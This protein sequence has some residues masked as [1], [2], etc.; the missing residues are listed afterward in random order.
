MDPLTL[1]ASRAPV[2]PPSA[3]F[4]NP[5]LAGL[6]PLTVTDEGRV[7]GHVAGWD[8]CHEGVIG[9]CVRPPRSKSGYAKFH[10]GVM[11]TSDGREVPVGKLTIM[12]GH[13]PTRGISE[14]QARAHYDDVATVAA[15]IRC[16]EDRFGIWLAGVLRNGVT[17]ELLRDVRAN[18]PSGDWRRGELVAVHCV[19]DQGFPIVRANVRPAEAEPVLALIASTG[20]GVVVQDDPGRRIRVL[21][22]RAEGIDALAELAEV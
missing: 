15:Y 17:G 20:L 3:W 14:K 6:T 12:G 18:G 13:A 22:A 7:Y 9:Q 21:A 4:R 1:A 16:G 10:T 19:P 8:S 11:H 2:A 5:N